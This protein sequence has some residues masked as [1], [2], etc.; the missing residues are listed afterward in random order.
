MELI[1]PLNLHVSGECS[2]QTALGECTFSEGYRNLDILDNT[3]QAI[4]EHRPTGH[5]V[6]VIHNWWTTRTGNI[7]YK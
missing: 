3:Q 2:V 4:I 5:T 6:L 7:S 1:K